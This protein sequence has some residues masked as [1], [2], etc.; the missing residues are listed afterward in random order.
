MAKVS[1]IS[2]G[3]MVAFFVTTG[4]TVRQVFIGY[5][6][7]LTSCIVDY[8]RQLNF[9]TGKSR[10]AMKIDMLFLFGLVCSFGLAFKVNTL[11]YEY[12]A[13]LWAI[14]MTVSCIFMSRVLG[15]L[16]PSSDQGIVSL[17]KIRRSLVFEFATGF[18]LLQL[19]YVLAPS[20][21]SSSDAVN[22]R[23]ALIVTGPSAVLA[24]AFTVLGITLI[25]VD[26]V[27]RLKRLYLAGGLV[28]GSTFALSLC[29]L[30][31]SPSQIESSL[32]P[33]WVDVRPLAL[34]MM[35]MSLTQGISLTTGLEMRWKGDSDL[36]IK[37]RLLSLPAIALA[38]S[39][40]LYTWGAQGCLLGLSIANIWTWLV[41]GYLIRP[42][43]RPS[44]LVD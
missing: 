20:I 6:V 3:V 4:A 44:S 8:F 23:L 11:D 17:K 38:P 40:G 13:S 10:E 34:P 39:I 36:S 5:L 35:L 22:L 31:A 33:L 27:G 1:M 26:P 15:G 32:G 7:C 12:L 28:F 19:L 14:T 9:I 30:A 2:L 29:L 16:R 43:R 41:N 25:M 42:R 24:Q 21:S 18:G 37:A